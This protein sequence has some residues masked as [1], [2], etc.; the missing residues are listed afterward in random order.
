[1]DSMY[2]CF[3]GAAVFSVSSINGLGPAIL[4]R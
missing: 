4:P 2:G 3:D 1:M